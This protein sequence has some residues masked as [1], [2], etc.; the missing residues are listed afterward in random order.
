MVLKYVITEMLCSWP[1]WLRSY[2]HKGQ[3]RGQFN[4]GWRV[5]C[6]QQGFVMTWHLG[7]F[8]VITVWASSPATCFWYSPFHPHWFNTG[9]GK[10]GCEA[11][12]LFPALRVLRRLVH[13]PLVKYSPS[14]FRAKIILA[15][16]PVE[17]NYKH[18]VTFFVG[19]FF[20]MLIHQI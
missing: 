2:K 3:Y 7:P 10:T 18:G 20:Y 15:N 9:Y 14:L 19:K 16:V 13:F 4:G 1:D 6:G 8:P 17:P 12:S 5:A 11:V